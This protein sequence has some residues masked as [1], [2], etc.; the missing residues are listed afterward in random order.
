M[1]SIG[2]SIYRWSLKQMH[3]HVQNSMTFTGLETDIQFHYITP[4][5]EER[6][7][8][9]YFSRIFSNHRNPINCWPLSFRPVRVPNN[10][11]I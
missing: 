4:G 10:T 3:Y 2:V 11:G 8:F 9:H 6:I 7:K 1:T 5:F